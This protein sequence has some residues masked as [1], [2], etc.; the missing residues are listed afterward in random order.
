MFL[1][2]SGRCLLMDLFILEVNT[3][4]VCSQNV[5]CPTFRPASDCDPA[6]PSS[7]HIEF[8]ADYMPS[9]EC[10]LIFKSLDLLRLVEE[11]ASTKWPIILLFLIRIVSQICPRLASVSMVFPGPLWGVN[12][13]G[14]KWVKHLLLL[15]SPGLGGVAYTASAEPFVSYRVLSVLS[16]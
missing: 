7:L 16:D 6:L 2:L 5:S 8:L 1:M 12:A 15:I 9:T 14:R 13:I 4:Y 10:V 11:P 3:S